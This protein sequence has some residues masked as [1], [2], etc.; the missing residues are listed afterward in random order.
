LPAGQTGWREEELKLLVLAAA[1]LQ[2]Q[3]DRLPT[4]RVTH[5]GEETNGSSD[6][7]S[8]CAESGPH[9]AP[10]IACGLVEVDF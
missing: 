10:P 9:G 7:H 6:A 1:G 3:G 2:Q 8:Q 5:H 4:E